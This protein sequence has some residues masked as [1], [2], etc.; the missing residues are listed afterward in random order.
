MQRDKPDNEKYSVTALVGDPSF[1]RWAL[2]NDP[3]VA[4]QW[5][6]WVATDPEYAA[7]A[8]TARQL[9]LQV[10]FSE[11]MPTEETLTQSYNRFA[12]TI[13]QL[14]QEPV[15]RRR[16][17]TMLSWRNAAIWTGLLVCLGTAAWYTWRQKTM[18]QVSTAFGETRQVA[19]PDSSLVTLR[20]NSTL[21]YRRSLN[22]QLREIW[23]K[24][25]AYFRV[26]HDKKAAGFIVHTPDADVTVLGT[27]FDLK[28]RHHR[29][30]VFLQ[31]GKVRVDF[32]DPRQQS[33]I[34]SP[35]DLVEYDATVKQVSASKT[36]SSYSSWV[37]GKLTL[38]DAPLSDIIDILENNYGE[39]VVVND[40]KIKDRKIEGIIY[41]ENKADILFII[42]NVLDIQIS[43][44]N[45]TMYFSNR[46]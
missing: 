35:G 9:L 24:G 5:E 4:A 2:Q 29:T 16:L 46:K 43:R 28:Q 14:H 8:E 40:E 32:H 25:E 30:A 38:V 45:D 37:Q 36:D 21:Q 39:K 18:L 27:A 10:R 31:S 3:A 33:R 12:H 44:R 20:A 7:L 23:L 6:T 26:N 13:A 42:S 1:V 19:L 22:G 34:L 15:L 17:Y 11:H 41:L